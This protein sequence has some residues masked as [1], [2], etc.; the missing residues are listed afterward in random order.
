MDG[1]AFDTLTRSLSTAGSRRRAVGGLLTGV[2]GVLGWRGQDDA[3]AHDLK[4]TCK[5]KSGEAKKKCLKK[6]KKHAAQHANE[7]CPQGQ[8][9]CRGACLSVLICCD[10]T[11]CAGGR[12]C[13]DGTCACPA[14][15]PHI[16][17]GS[18][19]CRECCALN[20]CQPKAAG[21]D[22]LACQSGQCVCTRNGTR[23]CA[24]GEWQGYCGECCAD[25]ECSGLDCGTHSDS[26]VPHCGCTGVICPGEVCVGFNCAGMCFAQCP[27]GVD[28]GEPCCT[29]LTCRQDFPGDTGGSC[30]P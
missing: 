28:I 21:F 13:Q 29:G 4:A 26:D 25:S 11:D 9:P 6:A 30:Q 18:Q 7:P 3:A 23:R 2:F 24:S 17:P 14:T 20:D 22:G 10:E 1:S 5:K 12:T 8:R 19:V 15:K 27:P 16:C